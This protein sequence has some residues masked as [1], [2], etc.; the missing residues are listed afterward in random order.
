ML[1][2]TGVHDY[3]AV[4]LEPITE[5]PSGMVQHFRPDGGVFDCDRAPGIEIVKNE[6]RLHVRQSHRK[7]GPGHLLA[8]DAGNR[9]A[10]VAASIKMKFV[11]GHECRCKEGKALH[12]VPMEVEK[13]VPAHRR[14]ITSVTSQP[15]YDVLAQLSDSGAGVENDQRVAKT[16]FDASCVSSVFERGGSR[17]RETTVDT[18][19][20]EEHGIFHLSSP[21]PEHA[22]GRGMGSVQFD[23]STSTVNM[24]KLRESRAGETDCVSIRSRGGEL[25][26]SDLTR[27]RGRALLKIYEEVNLT[28]KSL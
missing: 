22:R 16:Y 13:N 1:R 17:T 21:R 6:S 5:A 8:Y 14:S 9:G 28:E 26:L 23:E 18:P 27:G 7:V 2:V 10:Q 11:S 19:E 4:S 24:G 15:P 20:S 3:L 25:F 12:V